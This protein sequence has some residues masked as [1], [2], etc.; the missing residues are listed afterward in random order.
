MRAGRTAPGQ[1]MARRHQKERI[2]R[3][4]GKAS[5]KNVHPFRAPTEPA[6]SRESLTK[7]LPSRVQQDQADKAANDGHPDRPDIPPHSHLACS[8]PQL[9]C[10]QPKQG[11][12]FLEKEKNATRRLDW[13]DRSPPARASLNEHTR[14]RRRGSSRQR[15]TGQGPPRIWTTGADHFPSTTVLI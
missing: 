9:V 7:H 11:S 5:G 1:G 6:C 15:R 3:E 12:H 13:M 2:H 14:M 4:L 8:S 10:K